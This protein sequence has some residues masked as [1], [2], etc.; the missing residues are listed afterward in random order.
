MIE[1]DVPGFRLLRLEHL[2][3][4]YNGT[5][6]FDGKLLSGVEGLLRELSE[7]ITLHVLTADTFG[8]VSAC[9][10]GLPCQ[11]VLIPP[12]EQEKAKLG[13][14]RRLGK[15]VCC[16]VGNGRNDRLMLKEAALGI[17]LIQAEGAAAETLSAADLVCLSIQHALGL[18]LNPL[19]LKAT[20]RS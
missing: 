2:L 7:V 18:L 12:G 17:A 4:D 1:I 20:L 14:V 19:R 5:L 9:L 15:D 10:E 11:I 3:L 16:A 8:G 6:A 13:H